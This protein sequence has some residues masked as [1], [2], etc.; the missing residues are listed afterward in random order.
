MSVFPFQDTTTTI[1]WPHGLCPGLPQWVDTRKV[2]PIWIYW[3][4]R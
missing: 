1:L 3:S 4:K 2:N